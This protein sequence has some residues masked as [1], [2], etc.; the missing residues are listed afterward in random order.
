MGQRRM[1]G[2]LLGGLVA[3]LLAVGVLAAISTERPPAPTAQT[4]EQVGAGGLGL[5]EVTPAKPVGPGSM[6]PDQGP[7]PTTTA[8]K[9]VGPGST[10]PNQG[11]PPTTTPAVPSGPTATLPPGIS[12]P[13]FV[14]VIPNSAP[15]TVGLP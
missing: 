8:A 10:I 9:P 13:D 15:P 3:V 4:D 7:P 11:P 6:I 5:P 12:L 1:A 2:A 14:P